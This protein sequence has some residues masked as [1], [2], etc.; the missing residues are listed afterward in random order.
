[1]GRRNIGEL[2]V[3]AAQV[4]EKIEGSRTAG[5]VLGR[6]ISVIAV[7][8]TLFQLWIA[9][10]LPFMLGVGILTD[11]PARGVHLAFGLLLAFL[12]YPARQGRFD[13]PISWADIALAVAAA[14]ATLYLFFGYDGLVRR[15]GVLLEWQVGRADDPVEAIPRG[16]RDPAAA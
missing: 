10:P 12:L 9:S 14:G 8:W 15:Q 2:E 13:R 3:Q 6:V 4:L 5:P 7:L 11:V 16:C 1:M